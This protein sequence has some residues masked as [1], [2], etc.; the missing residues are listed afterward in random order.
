MRNQ[1]SSINP[2]IKEICKETGKMRLL[3]H[4]NSCF[5]LFFVVLGN[6]IIF[7]KNIIIVKLVCL[8]FSFLNVFEPRYNLF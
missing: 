4:W 5:Q 7:H 8:L 6:S 2:D 1:M 3:F